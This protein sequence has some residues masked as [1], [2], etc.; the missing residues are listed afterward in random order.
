MRSRRPPADLLITLDIIVVLLGTV[1]TRGLLNVVDASG[2][3]VVL[4]DL[5]AEGGS[6]ITAFIAIALN[7]LLVPFRDP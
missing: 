4:H 5:V 1:L 6:G 3:S 7:E 2:A